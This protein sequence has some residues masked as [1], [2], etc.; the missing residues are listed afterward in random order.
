MPP[1][2]PPVAP[3]DVAVGTSEPHGG[4]EHT[5]VSASSTGGLKHFR[6][7]ALIVILLAS[8]LIVWLI[9]RD[10]G[11]SSSNTSAPAVAASA[12]QIKAL[13]TSLGHPV[14]WLGPKAGTTYE[15]VQASN[16]SV[17]V[18]YLPPGSRSGRR[19]RT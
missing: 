11:G 16:G 2:S 19:I 9:L 15:L 4:I 18:R 3:P 14:F 1:Q 17:F 7:S 6:I 12:A 8:A 5:E 13:P 10:D